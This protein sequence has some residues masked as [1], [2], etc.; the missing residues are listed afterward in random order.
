MFFYYLEPCRIIQEEVSLHIIHPLEE[1]ERYI[2]KD[3]FI[4]EEVV[5]AEI[6]K[7]TLSKIDDR[8]KQVLSL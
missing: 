7:V 5:V 4:K 6:N 2:N 1:L 3:P 8:L